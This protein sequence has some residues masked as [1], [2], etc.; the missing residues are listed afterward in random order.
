MVSADWQLFKWEVIAKRS[1]YLLHQ[2]FCITKHQLSLNY[3]EEKFLLSF[4]NTIK[5]YKF[6]LSNKYMV[7][8]LLG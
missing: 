2:A 1:Y 3:D 8:F 6:P 4:D 5:I 7:F